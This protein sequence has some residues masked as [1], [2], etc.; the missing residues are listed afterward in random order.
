MWGMGCE[1]M[2]GLAG[3]IITRRWS[4]VGRWCVTCDTQCET[5]AVCSSMEHNKIRAMRNVHATME[6][7]IW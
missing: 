7:T 4:G 5:L 1:E 6:S 3:A 2:E